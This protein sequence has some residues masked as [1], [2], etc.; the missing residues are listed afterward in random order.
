MCNKSNTIINQHKA[1]SS[2]SVSANRDKL[3]YIGSG[4]GKEEITAE[5]TV[6]EISPVSDW[7]DGF[8]W[9]PS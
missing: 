1:A 6:F 9:E 2:K 3:R 4:Q 7:P 8:V 5:A